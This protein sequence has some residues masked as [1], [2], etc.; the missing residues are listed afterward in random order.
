MT[1]RT[2]I[3]IALALVIPVCGCGPANKFSRQSEGDEVAGRKGTEISCT[4]GH[5]VRPFAWQHVEKIN[6]LTM[7]ASLLPSE[8]PECGVDHCAD[9]CSNDVYHQ[10]EI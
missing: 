1:A 9:D 7:L 3:A 8:T 10:A 5:G 4:G 2:L 6:V